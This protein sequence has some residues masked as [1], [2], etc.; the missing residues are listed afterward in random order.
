MDEMTRKEKRQARRAERRANRKPFFET[1][2]GGILKGVSSVI[3]PN[4]V[5]ALEGVEDI[6]EALKI[7]SG[8]DSISDETRATLRELALKEYEIEVMDRTSAREREVRV[9]E[10][11]GSNHLMSVL[12][13]GVTLTFMAL[14]AVTLGLV[15][16]PEDLNKEYFMFGAGAVSSSFMTV[17]AYYFGSSAGSKQKTNILGN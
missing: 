9:L 14:V 15:D 3:A 1:K 5:G 12:G 4:L 6:S 16:L 2:V 7:I 17:L 10:A 11:G 8:E 13:W